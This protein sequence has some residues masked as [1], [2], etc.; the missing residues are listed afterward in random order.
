MASEISFTADQEEQL[1]F[2]FSRG[3]DIVAVREQMRYQR[4]AHQEMWPDCTRS[5]LETFRQ[6]AQNEVSRA[7]MARTN[8]VVLRGLAQRTVQVARAAD[9]LQGIDIL[10]EQLERQ[11]LE[12]I[13]KGALQV[14]P[15]ALGL[16]N[17]FEAKEEG[18]IDIPT[19]YPDKYEK[20]RSTGLS[21][22][23]LYVLD[24][25][26]DRSMKIMDRLTTMYGSRAKAFETLARLS[27][28]IDNDTPIEQDLRLLKAQELIQIL[29]DRKAKAENQ[30]LPELTGERDSA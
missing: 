18:V 16:E 2:W 25:M 5:Q 6:K 29:R 1:I 17:D 3:D 10:V 30:P 26:F 11:V 9:E 23:A 15:S 8:Q 13:A 20:W 7:M 22:R 24:M 14:E 27:G 21:P 12:L 4:M 19:V 28:T